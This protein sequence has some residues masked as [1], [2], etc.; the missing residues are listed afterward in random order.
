MKKISFIIFFIIILMTASVYAGGKVSGCGGLAYPP[1]MWKEG[2]KIVGVGPDVA[3]I[4]FKELNLD[5]E[6]ICFSSWNRCMREVEKGRVDLFF[7]ASVNEERSA[8]ADFTKNYLSESPVGVFIWKER[9]IQ[10]EKWEDLIGKK[11]GSI[12]G[13]TYGQKFDDFAAKHIEI[14]EVITPIQ[15]FK[16]LEKGRVDFL[17]IG[18]YTGLIHI[19]QF[20]YTDKI[21]AADNYLETGHLYAAISKLSPYLKHLP[22][23]D[24][25]LLELR[26]DGTIKRLIDK[27]IDYYVETAK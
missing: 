21:V 11:M 18:L 25:R 24:K 27:Y 22:Y 14:S 20:G 6:S 15:N 3:K 7:A 1:F 8:F 23:L 12:L 10:F 4:I 16:K 26:E 17:P 13:T 19:K 2:D 5:V 9:P